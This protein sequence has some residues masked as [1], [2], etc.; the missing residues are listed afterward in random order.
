LEKHIHSAARKSTA[1]IIINQQNI[2]EGD[3]SI[4]VSNNNV[5]G[6]VILAHGSGSSR[7]SP[8][9]KYVAQE[10]NNV[11]I[12]TLV[13][14]M[15]TIEEES[16]DSL[17]KEHR[18]NIQLL[19]QRLISCTD[20]TSQNSELKN[21]KIGYF[22]ASTGAA[23]ALVAAAARPNVVRV[24]VSRGGRPDLAGKEILEQIE[25]PTLLIVGENDKEVIELNQKALELLTR[26]EKKKKLILIPNATHLFEEEGA[27]EE[28]ARR[29]RG[30]FECFFLE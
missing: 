13:V 26:I 9:S 30:W 25:A 5:K 29:A 1:K 20:W 18:F 10:L 15:L 27:L 19:A 3:L 28:V 22:G 16:V 17:T 8:R 7:H 11:G 6:I 12:A 4:P 23:A 21:L 24:V 2:I 14:D